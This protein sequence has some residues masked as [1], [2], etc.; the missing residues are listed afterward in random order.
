MENNLPLQPK[1]VLVCLLSLGLSACKSS[2]DPKD[3]VG[4]DSGNTPVDSG[5]DTNKPGE[6]AEPCISYAE[7]LAD[8]ENLAVPVVTEA[9]DYY[10]G[11]DA[12]STTLAEDLNTLIGDHDYLGFNSLWDAFVLTDSRTD[13]KVWD[14]YSVVPEG[15]EPFYLYDFESGR[16]GDYQ[17][18][19]Y[20]Y[21]REHSF[22]SSWFDGSHPMKSDLFHVRPTDGYVNN[23]RGNAPFSPTSRSYW[24]SK[25][26]SVLGKSGYCGFS[27]EAFEPVDAVKGDLA[28]GLLYVSLRYRSEDADWVG[29][30]ATVGALL[31]PWAEE[32]LRGWHLMDPVDSREIARNEAVF[33]IQGNRNPLIDHPE[34]VCQIND[35]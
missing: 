10:A 29:S 5:S 16:C 2:G 21:N 35:F 8:C 12:D 4:E 22:P 33:A 1:I 25:N 14:V 20:C 30:E 11:I 19:G 7:V 6:T 9:G 15:T 26:G 24:T 23:R 31:E 32:V 3:S 28:R 18:E 17:G 34:W 13:G 27:G